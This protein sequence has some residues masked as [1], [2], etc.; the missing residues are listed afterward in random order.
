[1]NQE[2]YNQ[3]LGLLVQVRDLL[4]GIADG[5]PTGP[6]PTP[7]PVPST[8]TPDDLS[9]KPI[10]WFDAG[11]GINQVNSNVLGWKSRVGEGLAA[12]TDVA[13]RPGYKPT[14]HAGYPG[15]S[16]RDTGNQ[17]LETNISAS[18]ATLTAIAVVNFK[19]VV[20]H[21]ARTIFGASTDGGLQFRVNDSGH[22]DL[23]KMNQ[24]LI[25]RSSKT[26]IGNQP[27][28]V[29]GSFSNKYFSFRV[30]GEDFGTGTH[31]EVLAPGS[32]IWLMDKTW[33]TTEELNGVL[34]EII[35][36]GYVPDAGTIANLERYLSL[37]YG[38][39]LTG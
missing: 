12:Q 27:N 15:V 22:L 1:M 23:L 11:Y 34:Q 6:T 30:N 13:K 24:K 33:S 36:L 21:E 9:A 10:A 37:K 38:I 4:K 28:I 31:S 16:N 3:V 29:Y 14:A 19:P 7:T 2:Q 32:H 8:W 20:P 26:V 17:Y 5:T 35:F 18:Y 25:A 39:P